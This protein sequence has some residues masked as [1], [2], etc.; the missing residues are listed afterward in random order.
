MSCKKSWLNVWVGSVESR[1]L[2]R[3]LSIQCP[4]PAVSLEEKKTKLALSAPSGARSCTRPDGAKD[5]ARKDPSIVILRLSRFLVI[6]Q[7]CAWLSFRRLVEVCTNPCYLVFLTNF[8]SNLFTNRY[9][10]GLRLRSL[11]SYF[12]AVPEITRKLDCNI[13]LVYI[14]PK[15]QGQ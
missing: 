11:R 14:R 4:I 1:T 8:E 7:F 9:P 10:L 3:C 13:F 5:K 6:M 2:Q 12:G 15:H